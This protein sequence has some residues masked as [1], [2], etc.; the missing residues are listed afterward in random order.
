MNDLFG[1]TAW[2]TI[3]RKRVPESPSDG[4][5]K[6]A[7][8]EKFTV[9]KTIPIRIFHVFYPTT[10]NAGEVNPIYNEGGIR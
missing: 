4:E 3:L 10:G 1:R 7:R 5:G 6:T 2:L 8:K 9:K